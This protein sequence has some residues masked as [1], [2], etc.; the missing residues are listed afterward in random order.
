MKSIISTKNNSK[1]LQKVEKM[2]KLSMPKSLLVDLQRQEI[3]KQNSFYATKIGAIEVIQAI[4]LII[5]YFSTWN[6]G[7]HTVPPFRQTIGMIMFS[8]RDVP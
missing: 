4:V 7:Q 1:N 6:T 2:F 3:L 8:F 5:E